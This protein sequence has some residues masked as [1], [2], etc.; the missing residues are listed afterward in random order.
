[1]MKM[2][3]ETNNEYAVLSTYVTDSAELKH[4]VDGEHGVNGLFEV[5]HLCM[6]TFSGSFGLVRN[7]G[8]KSCRM[9]PHPKLTNAVWGAGLSFSK[10]HA[11]R[12]VPY[13]PHTPGM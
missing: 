13:D 6:V 4:N 12:K 8:T 5:P 10:C 1:M 3:S 9:L 7:W 2:W 11:E